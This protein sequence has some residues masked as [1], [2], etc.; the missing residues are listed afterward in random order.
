M[1]SER[2]HWLERA[3]SY[4]RRSEELEKQA[5][6]LLRSNEVA[7]ASEM[8]WGSVATAV[9]ALATTKGVK[10]ASHGKMKDFVKQ[11]ALEARDEE[12]L[13]TFEEVAEQLHANFYHEF[14][15]AERVYRLVQDVHAFNRKIG[16]LVERTLR[17]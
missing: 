8:L 16:E 9:L 14:L 2:S 1:S 15:S 4:L 3:R 13:R 6:E 17:G 5:G 12:I 11:L 7:K 10:L